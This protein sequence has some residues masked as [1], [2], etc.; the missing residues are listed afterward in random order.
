ME[1]GSRQCRNIRIK[2]EAQ[3]EGIQMIMNG[4]LWNTIWGTFDENVMFDV[5]FIKKWCE[6]GT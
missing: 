4:I 1:L 5:R 2:E 6:E 3:G